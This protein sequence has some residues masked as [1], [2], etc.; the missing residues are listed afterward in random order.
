MKVKINSCTLKGEVYAPT[1]KSM[2][3][4]LLICA[5]LAKGESVISRVTFSEDILATLDCLEAMGAKYSING[6]TV[7]INGI[8]D[9]NLSQSKDFFCRESGSTLRF[10][11]PLLLLSENEQTLHGKGRLMSRPMT[12]YEDICKLNNLTF[13]QNET[14]KVKG[15]L[16]A[17]EYTVPGNISSQFITGLLFALS[18]CDGDSKIKILEPFESASYVNMTLSAMDCFGADFETNGLEIIVHGGKTFQPQTMAVE[19]DFSGSA[20]LDVFNYIG[21]EVNVLGMNEKSLQGDKIYRKY[22]ELLDYGSP[23]LDISDCPDLAPVLMTLAVIKNGCKLLNTARLKIKESD[24]GVVMARELAKFGA[25]IE[26]KENE[27]VIH[28]AK[29]HSPDELL[30]GHNDHRVV[31]SLAVISTLYGG[32]ITDAQAVAKSF[33][34]FFDVLTTLNAE[35]K[36]NA[37]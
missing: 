35:V 27:I 18:V 28:K 6:D 11:L 9:F 36:I 26:V 30:C 22:F 14:I 21:G 2:A 1:S 5:A 17:G 4:R 23:N 34:N 31:M 32:E 19:G 13:I 7:T 37:D 10:I 8:E 16:K 33:P 24:R 15:V 3:H 20:F 25:D 29:L 12:V